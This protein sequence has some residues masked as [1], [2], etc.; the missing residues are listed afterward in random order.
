MS[1]LETLAA[2]LLLMN[3]ALLA[4]RSVWNF[5]AGMAAVAIY[6]WVFFDARLYAVAGLQMFFLLAQLAGLMAWRRAPTDSGEVAVRTMPARWWPCV[7][8]AGVLGSAALALLLH[9]T[10]AAAPISDGI[11]TAFSLVAQVLT[12]GRYVQSWPLWAGVNIMS[13]ALFAG[14][15]LWITAG[16]YGLLLTIALYSWR[17]WTLMLAA[18]TAP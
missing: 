12:N 16:L 3:S 11:V 18:D 10:N 17:A 4:R 2:I 7:M 13:I 9:Q 8:M 5:P 14:Q 6:A 1:P 15:D